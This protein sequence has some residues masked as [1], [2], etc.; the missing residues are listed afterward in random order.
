VTLQKNITIGELLV[1]IGMFFSL[2]IAMVK[3]GEY[4]GHLDETLQ[5]VN[6]MNYRI[7]EVQGQNSHTQGQ[8]ASEKLAIIRLTQRMK[9]VEQWIALVRANQKINQQQALVVR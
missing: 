6:K 7:S 1:L 8:V 2:M 9:S 3:V 4:K 5:A